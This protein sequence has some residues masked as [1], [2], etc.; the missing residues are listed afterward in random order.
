VSSKAQ[1]SN[2]LGGHVAAGMRPDDR[3]S[4]RDVTYQDRL[5]PPFVLE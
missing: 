5:K 3:V 1:L 4:P 2:Y